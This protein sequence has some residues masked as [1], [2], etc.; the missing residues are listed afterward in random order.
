MGFQNSFPNQ[1]AI[2]IPFD[3]AQPDRF[4]RDHDK[5]SDVILVGAWT[6]PADPPVGYFIVSGEIETSRVP[7]WLVVVDTEGLSVLTA[8]VK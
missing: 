3:P 7:A 8:W 5:L 4:D 6:G 2:V 1:R